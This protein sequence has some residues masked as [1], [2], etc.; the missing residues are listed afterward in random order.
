VTK[1]DLEGFRTILLEQRLQI[2]AHARRMLAEDVQIDGDDLAD[3]V[4]NAVS[5]SNAS[6]AGQMRERERGLLAQVE[7]ALEKIERGNYG[8]CESC[9]EEI[10][11]GRLRARPV[12][13]SCIDC[14]GEEERLE[15]QRV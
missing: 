2:I 8:A 14:Q 13:E 1:T 4:D 10:G 3:E 7:R 12:A 6:F 5:D 15:R 9:G 11:L